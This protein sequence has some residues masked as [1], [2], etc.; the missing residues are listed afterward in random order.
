[1]GKKRP[2]KCLLTAGASSIS[3][4]SHVLESF[5]GRSF[6]QKSTDKA[7][8]KHRQGGGGVGCSGTQRA[9]EGA[10]FKDPADLPVFAYLEAFLGKSL[11]E[12]GKPD[13]EEKARHILS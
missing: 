7:K 8:R 13:A 11:S 4:S 1:M 5:R 12:T 10:D 2:E 3:L 9:L 6:H